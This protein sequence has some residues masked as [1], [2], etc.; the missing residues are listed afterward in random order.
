M[1]N[2]IQSLQ[3]RDLGHLR[4]VAGLWGMELVHV[5]NEAAL[6][7]LTAVL[8]DPDQVGEM[9][10]SLSS[11][12]RS[13]LETLVE[14]G[15]KMPWAAFARQFGEIRETGPGRRDREQAYL[16]PVSVAETLFYRAFL[17]RAFFDTPNGPQE[18][19]YIP[20]D[21]IEFI[22]HKKYQEPQGKPIK[23]AA[24]AEA[25]GSE[26]LGRLANPKERQHPIPAT[27]RLLDDAT[28]FLAAL[29]MGLAVPEMQTPAGMVSEIS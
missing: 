24:S 14:A 8:L 20:D 9:V 17:A 5:E 19:A 26:P 22:K 4:I 27:D 3:G 29:R 11:Q 10:D 1:P 21:L 12:A 2:L 6:Q 13:A 16:N 18:F 7:E 15:G 25:K 23:L 28:T